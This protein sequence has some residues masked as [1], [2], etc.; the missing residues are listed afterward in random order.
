MAMS[1]DHAALACCV[2]KDLNVT[3]KQIQAL[4]T[5]ARASGGKDRYKVRLTGIEQEY[6]NGTEICRFEGYSFQGAVT[7]GNG[8]NQTGGKMGVGYVN[9][10]TKKETEAE[11][12]GAKDPA[13]TVRN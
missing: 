11:E 12:G 2:H 7:A 1:E 8:P 3:T 9:S 6:W 13:Q 10:R 4:L 5:A